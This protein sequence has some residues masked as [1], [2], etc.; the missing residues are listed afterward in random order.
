MHRSRVLSL[1]FV[2]LAALAVA[3]RPA[4]AQS[5]PGAFM[6]DMGNHVL[7]IIND[8]VTPEAQRKQQFMQ[9]VE[10]AFDMP[11]I[12]QFVLGRYYRTATP[13]EKQQ[14]PKA[15]ETYM[16]QVYWSRFTSYNGETFR[17]TDSKDEGNGTTVVT[18][19]IL[20][21]GG[22]PSVKVDWQITKSGDSFKIRD[23][24][25]EGVSQ[26]LTYRDEFASIIERGGGKV[27]A[28]IDQLNSRAKGGA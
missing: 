19:E 6:M 20:R 21:G 7:K 25:L 1:A 2:L 24:S 9:L 10:S 12:S 27:S 28:L 15:F 14:F 3:A 26:A 17:V 5:D 18:T 23:A 22:Q 16:V 8:K 13:D 11:K 4:A